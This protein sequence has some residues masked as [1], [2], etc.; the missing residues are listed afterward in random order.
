MGKKKKRK[1]SFI[2][3]PK[4]GAEGGQDKLLLPNTRNERLM[5][6]K[7]IFWLRLLNCWNQMN[8]TIVVYNK[9]QTIL[10]PNSG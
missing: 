2:V 7:Y 1:I 9:N 6:K 4:S 8:I 3:S 10:Q 5:K